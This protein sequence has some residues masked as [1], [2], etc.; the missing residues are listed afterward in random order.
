MAVD[1]SITIRLRDQFTKELRKMRA[2]FKG[3]G[4]NLQRS[5]E[6]FQKT[7]QAA[8]NMSLA[9]DN[10]E[11][12]AQKGQRFIRMFSDEAI[13]LEDAMARVHAKTGTV[14]T[15]MAKQLSEQARELGK[16]TTFT[17][18]EVAQAQDFL[19]QAG[20]QT[21]EILEA[22]PTM[23]KLSRIGALDLAEAADIATNVTTGLRLEIEDTERVSA[24]LAKTAV[25]ANTDVRQMGEAMSYAAPAAADAGVEVEQLGA[26]MGILGDAG[27][28]ASRAGTGMRAI[29]QRL[30]P[31]GKAARKAM[32]GLG[33]EVEDPDTGNLREISEIL[34]QVQ[35]KTQDLSGIKRT[36]FLKQVFGERQA[37]V[38]SILLEATGSGKLQER[39]SQL[40]DLDGELDRLSEQMV[41]ETKRSVLELESAWSGFKEQI[42]QDLL[43]VLRDLM[44]D[45]KPMI[46][47][48]SEWARENPELVRTLS[49]V[50]VMSTAFTSALGPLIRVGSMAT[51][52]IG[53]TKGLVQALGGLKGA[54]G[55]ATGGSKGLTGAIAPL[56]SKSVGFPALGAATI[57]AISAMKAM[58]ELEELSEKERKKELQEKI[59]GRQFEEALREGDSRGAAEAQAALARLR[60]D[61]EKARQIED[62]AGITRE[63]AQKEAQEQFESTPF[64]QAA[65]KGDSSLL[66]EVSKEQQEARTREEALKKLADA[67]VNGIQLSEDTVAK[68]KE[69]A[70]I[71]VD[72]RI[73]VDQEGNVRVESTRVDGDGEAEVDAGPAVPGAF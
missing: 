51:T 53:G 5:K 10:V 62:E 1:T 13:A 55:G 36:Q 59:L 7:F 46:A 21:N 64:F 68:L 34:E 44:E 33:I 11:Q 56:L 9:A 17:A 29:L 73:V 22:T 8:G 50:I 49:K 61:E 15:Q 18:L 23:L 40:G 70:N 30:V 14:G 41:G 67:V 27:I 16:T 48:L 42:A 12:L 2:G 54:A 52:V 25:S 60:G 63:K 26:M 3:F 4:D 57:A 47:G 45:L 6:T 43:P 32:R 69:R 38:A 37:G 28:Q 65:Q 72:A 71:G 24:V 58:K 20:L 39:I 35:E 31:T 66:G 19:A